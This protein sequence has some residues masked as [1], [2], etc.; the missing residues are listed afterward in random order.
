MINSRIIFPDHNPD[1]PYYYCELESITLADS[2]DT[3]FL[4]YNL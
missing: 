4:A 1:K 2:Q 3:L